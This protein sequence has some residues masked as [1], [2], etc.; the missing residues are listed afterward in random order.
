MGFGRSRER[1]TVE[2]LAARV[3]VGGSV[4]LVVRGEAGIGRTTLLDHLAARAQGCR[5]VRAA[6]SEDG[7]ELPLAELHQRCGR[8]LGDVD[9]LSVLQRE[10]LDMAFGL[11]DGP[12]LHAF[13]LGPAT[14]NTVAEAARERPLICLVDD[15]QWLDRAVVQV[16]G[17]VARRLQAESVGPACAVRG[18]VSLVKVVGQDGGMTT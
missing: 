15:A 4:A 18:P 7:M 8:L 5:T 9:H 12:D 16:L 17:F 6:G 2:H 10:A 13:L 1:E 3:R 11:A 14:L